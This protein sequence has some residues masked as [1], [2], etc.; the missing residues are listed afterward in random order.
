MG[1]SVRYWNTDQTP[2]EAL[3]TLNDQQERTSS[4]VTGAYDFSGLLDQQHTIKIEKSDGVDNSIRAYDASLILSHALGTQLLS[5]P[6]LASAD[7]TGDGTVSEQD[8]AKV[9]EVAA[10]L[11]TVPFPNQASPWKFDP[12]ERRFDSLTNDISN[13]DFTG[14]FMGDVSGNWSGQGI[15]SS[16][17][18]SLEI[19]DMVRRPSG[20]IIATVNVFAGS[21]LTSDAVSALELSMST[22]S[23]VS[24]MSV[25]RTPSTASWSNPI[26]RSQDNVMAFTTYD[27]VSGALTGE[28]HVLTLTLS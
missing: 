1:G 21:E 4:S 12:Q 25:E 17:G 24:L 22:T 26:I 8:A 20:V 13:A 11:A 7:V 15:Q 2:I 9:L 14:L 18:F 3:L 10:G 16:E 6:A 27:D 19:A 5:G 28:H 23:G